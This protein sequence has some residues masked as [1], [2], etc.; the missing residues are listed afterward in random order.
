MVKAHAGMDDVVQD[1]FKT[2]HETLAEASRRGTE[3]V[4][5]EAVKVVGSCA[6]IL[7]QWIHERRLSQSISLL[8][9]IWQGV[10]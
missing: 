2:L 3:V 4:Q 1:L 5:T 8:H 10:N 7:D 6:T 9:G